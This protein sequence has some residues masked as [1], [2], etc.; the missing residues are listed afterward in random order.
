[1]PPYF[2]A[3]IT[4]V[5]GAISSWIVYVPKE[6]PR[7][8][9]WEPCP[10]ASRVLK[11]RRLSPSVTRMHDHF[12]CGVPSERMKGATL[13]PR[14]LPWAGMRHPFRAIPNI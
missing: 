4:S 12:G 2:C 11:E 8:T 10:A 1:M 9:L 14:A 6:H 13:K 3:K 7:A 5:S